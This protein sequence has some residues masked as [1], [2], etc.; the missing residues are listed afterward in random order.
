MQ[1]DVRV[2]SLVPSGL[3]SARRFAGSATVRGARAFR[4]QGSLLNPGPHCHADA[5]LHDTVKI[6]SVGFPPSLTLPCPPSSPCLTVRRA[7]S[8][9]M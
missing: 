8:V 5:T 3:C 9:P 2:G 4:A 1:R 7:Q 6:L